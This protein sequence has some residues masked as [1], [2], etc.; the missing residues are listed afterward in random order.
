MIR[1]IGPV[2]AARIHS[3]M[4]RVPEWALSIICFLI[5]CWLTLVPHP[6]GDFDVML[7]PGFDKVMHGVMFFGLTLSMLFDAMRQRQWKELSL[8]VISL[9]AFIGMGIGIGIEFLQEMMQAGRGRE[10]LDMAADIIGAVVA[11]S[12]WMVI[13]GGLADKRDL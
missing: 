5:I 10:W 6:V 12:L 7:F 4:K 3:F 9:I 11:A 8:P 2:T 1:V 13:S